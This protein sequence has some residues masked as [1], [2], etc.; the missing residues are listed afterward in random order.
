MTNMT[1]RKAALLA[2]IEQ[3]EPLSIYQ[4]AGKAGRNYRRVHDHVHE[5][6]GLGLVRIRRQI[7]NGRNV[8]I[9]EHP[10]HQRLKHLDEMYAFR[11]E[12]H[13]AQ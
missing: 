2:M 12:I 3:S 9:V 5:F 4:L 7:R 6:A 10:C 8:S 1:K 11:Q 13:A